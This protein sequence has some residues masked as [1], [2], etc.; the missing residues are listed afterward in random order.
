MRKILIILL[1][2]ISTNSQAQ[3]CWKKVSTVNDNYLRF[4]KANN[5]KV[6]CSAGM[7]NGGSVVNYI[8]ESTNLNTWIVN[9][10]SF[11]SSLHLFFNKAANGDLYVPTAHNGVYKS[12]NNGTSWSYNMGAGFG[13]GGLTFEQDTLGNIYMGLGGGCRGIY[14]STNNGS[15]W[16]NKIGGRDFTDIHYHKKSNTVYASNTNFE[17]YK[18]TDNGNTWSIITGQSFSGVAIMT[19]TV[20]NNIWIFCRDGKIY[21]SANSGLTWSLKSTIPVTSNASGYCNKLIRNSSGD[22]FVSFNHQGIWYST[23]GL[24]WNRRDSCINATYIF[25]LYVQND[26]ILASANNGI[27]MYNSCNPKNLKQVSIGA[28]TQSYCGKDSVKLTATSGFKSYA[29]SNGKT[30]SS[31]FA[32]STGTYTIAATDS[33]GCTVYDTAVISILNPKISP[34]DTVACNGNSVNLSVKNV[35][36]TGN[37]GTMDAGLKSGMTAWYPFCGNAN[38]QVG[39]NNGSV[40]GASLTTGELNIP[41]TAYSFNGSSNYIG[42]NQPFL[43]GGQ[44]SE[45]T[46]R[47]KVKFNSLSNNPNFWIKT[48]FWGEIAWGVSNNSLSLFWAN[49][50]TGNKYSHIFTD[51]SIVKLK[52]AK[53][54][55]L[56]VTFKNSKGIIYI[57][58]TPVA[59]KMSW[60]AQGGALLST[61]QVEASANF[62]QDAGSSR[63]GVRNIGGSWVNYL[64]GNIDEFN[65][66]N[67]ALTASE[68]SKIYTQQATGSGKFSWS[69]S[70]TTTT[71]KITQTGKST[72]WVKVSNGIGSC[73]DTTTVRIQKPTVSMGKD[74]QSFC[75]VDSAKLTA[76]PGF[77]SYAWS[78]GKKGASVYANT[79]GPITVTATDS[80]GCTA[81]DATLISIQNPRILPRDTVVC[82]GQAVTLRVKDTKLIVSDCAAL[83]SVLKTGLVSWWPFCGNA[84]DESGNG[85]HGILKGIQYSTDRDGKINN[86]VEITSPS[87]IMCTKNKIVNPSIFT[88]SLWFKTNSIVKSHI[89]GFDDGQCKHIFNQD[90]QIGIESNGKLFFHVNRP[91]SSI[92]LYSNLTYND[93]KWHHCV[94]SLSSSGMKIFVDGKLDGFNS[95][96]TVT[97]YDGYWRIGGLDSTAAVPSTIASV[98]DIIIWQRELNEHEIISLY[99]KDYIIYT[100]SN[101]SIGNSTTITVKGNNTIWVKSDDAI[102]T[103]YDTTTVRI[104]NPSLNVASDTL[105]FTNCKR[106]SLRVSVGKKWK[107]VQ[108]SH[109]PK[110]SAVFLKTT[111]KYS[112]RVQ[113]SV[114]CFVADT[115]NF[116]NPGRVKASITR[117]D[118]VKC[119]NGNTGSATGSANGGFVPLQYSWSNGQTGT[120]A[121]GLNQGSYAFIATDAYG[122]RDTAYAAIKQPSQTI[123]GIAKIDSIT[124][125]NFSNGSITTNGSGGTA[126]YQFRWQ[127]GQ[128]GNTVSNLPAGSYRVYLTDKNGCKD[129][130]IINLS[131][132]PEVIARIVSGNMTLKGQNMDVAAQVTPPGNYTYQ[133]QPTSVF[134]SNANKQNASIQLSNNTK[135]L[136]TATNTKGCVGKDS[137]E[138]GVVQPLK[139]IIPNA[140][141]PN[142]DG[143]NEGFGLPD[144]F[145]IETFQVYDRWGGIIFK[146][147]SSIPR[148]N[149]YAGNEPVPAGTYSYQITAKLKGGLQTVSYTGKVTV[150]K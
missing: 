131:N 57:D 103:C 143:L 19:K 14:V 46:L 113:D 45:F 90:R 102:G 127:G 68:I 93:N 31:I 65:V 50:I 24:S 105:R 52:T 91:P 56:V 134:G 73:Y 122:C 13:C 146:G 129:S 74:T 6:Y 138:I 40:N 88:V 148:W 145:E 114:G 7:P 36:L 92:F 53:W 62:Q 39:T 38:D 82:S 116:I 12:T 71:T 141:S 133:W 89:F 119:Y 118:S 66:W 95:N 51:T 87:Q 55:D 16:S 61:S 17:I 5:G 21:E 30:G 35:T 32:N 63:F 120:N 78:N 132:P 41:N 126:P 34:R 111:G 70:D 117:T 8:Y 100:W 69:T 3:T 140:F 97:P 60:S 9:S 72:V 26:T 75:R 49:N 48:L 115:F 1:L 18:S 106:D 104:S 144:I 124:C 15:T 77:A 96:S 125:Y 110:D 128:T 83:P 11:P 22:Y 33:Q 149:G 136:L 58:G 98:D 27:F 64:N 112:V 99:R 67:R 85:N 76:T 20:A 79:T 42:L 80:F 23:N 109:G 150:I 84:N 2:V 47:T 25:D 123:V 101:S 4:V 135:L 81:S 43:G 147:S 137:L 94:Y 10:S 86:A 142:K 139:D 121:T 59:T 28:N 108:W 37:C 44:V 54:Y 130:L 29:W 107:A